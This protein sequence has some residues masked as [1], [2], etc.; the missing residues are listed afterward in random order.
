MPHETWIQS[1]DLVLSCQLILREGE[2]R[3]LGLIASG[4]FMRFVGMDIRLVCYTSPHKK[5]WYKSALELGLPH[6]HV[7]KINRYAL[8][9]IH[10][11]PITISKITTG[12]RAASAADR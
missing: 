10:H 2:E 6:Y 7:K 3:Q 4:H 9:F 5:K 1:S 12:E 8:L 11:Q